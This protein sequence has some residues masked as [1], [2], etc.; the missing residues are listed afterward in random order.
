[1][2][3]CHLLGARRRVGVRWVQDVQ[4][5]EVQTHSSVGGKQAHGRA[6]AARP[7]VRDVLPGGVGA[8]LWCGPP[9]VPASAAGPAG[10]GYAHQPPLLRVPAEMWAQSRPVYRT[11]PSRGPGTAFSPPTWL[12][13]T[14]RLGAPAHG[15]KDS[16]LSAKPRKRW[17]WG[18]ADT[19]RF[20][21][22]P[23]REPVPKSWLPPSLAAPCGLSDDR[24]KAHTTGAHTE[25]CCGHPVSPAPP[26]P[27][28]RLLGGEGRGGQSPPIPRLSHNLGCTEKVPAPEATAFL[29]EWPLSEPPFLSP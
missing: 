20:V 10:P 2:R 21:C 5:N 15:G 11:R 6:P 18:K 14:P 12:S 24:P 16:S 19:G 7:F 8:H 26:L 23:E 29:P 17:P 4:R 13:C 22:E 28:P 25:G 3:Q 27:A 9:T 1:M